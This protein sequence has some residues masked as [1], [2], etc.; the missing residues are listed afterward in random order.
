MEYRTFKQT[1]LKVSRLCFG[2]MTFGK[3]VDQ[4]TATRMVDLCL[5][6]GIN[7]FDTANI[8]Q[9]GQAEEMLGHAI[10]GRRDGVIVA[11]KVRGK[12]GD[13][14]DDVGLS[15]RAIVRAIEDSLR[16]LQTDYLDLYY[17]HQPDYGT[18]IDE[19]LEAMER[20][21]TEG[22]VRYPATSNYSSWQVCQMLSLARERDYH[23]A[24]EVAQP[25]ATTCWREGIEQEFL[26]MSRELGVAIIVYNPLAGGLLTG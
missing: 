9:L 15:R 8:Y 10:R 18:P 4:A 23:P 17:L 5:D 12:M 7:F 11:S 3:P 13:G 14:P 1:D 26:P 22:K 6:R 19:T 16:R 20:L 21:V 25:I 2:T 24:V